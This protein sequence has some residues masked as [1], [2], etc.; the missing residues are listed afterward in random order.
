MRLPL[1]CLM[2]HLK[3]SL[4]RRL[5]IELLLVTFFGCSVVASAATNSIPLTGLPQNTRL[6]IWGDSITEVTVYPRYI[7]MYLLACAG[8]KDIK[9]CTFGHSGETLAG[10][11]SR[12]IDLESF[13]PT[14]VMFNEGMNDTKYSPYTPEKGAAYDQT[15]K[16]VL[17]MLTGKGITQKI[18]AGPP[19]VDDTY[20]ADAAGTSAFFGGTNTGGLTAAQ[21]QNVNLRNFS[22]FGRT[23]AVNTGSAF[24]DIFDRMQESYKAA[25]AVYGPKYGYEIHS[26][27]NGC[28]LMD[29]E[30]LKTL[31]CDGS[32]GAINVDMNGGATASAGHTVV[33]CSNGAVVLDSSKYPFCYNYDPNNTQGFKSLDSMLPYVPFSRDLNR[34]TL[35]VTNLKAPSANVTWGGQTKSFTSAQLTAGVNLAEQFSQTPF[36]ATFAQVMARIVNK[37]NYED[38]MIKGTSNYFGND[39]GGNVDNNMIAVETSLDAA[40]KALIVPVRHTIAIVPTGAPGPVVPVITGAMMAYPMVGQPFAYQISALNTPTSFS[41]TGLPAGLTMNTAGQITGTPTATGVSVASI[42]AA[43]ASGTSETTLTLTVQ[44]PVPN[45]PAITSS[46]AASGM[47]GAPFSYQTTATNNPA[48]YFVTVPSDKG[49]EPPASS[50]PTGITYNT[51]SGLVSGTFTTAG[52]YKLQVA[53]MN[54]AGVA[55]QFVTVTVSAGSGNSSPSTPAGST[56]AAAGNG[57]NK[58]L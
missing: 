32:I 19:F 49:T 40:V 37:Q 54:G 11:L 5:Y 28:I 36:D 17:A 23:E 2:T 27:P 18:V 21:G 43:N 33:S 6:A 10:L 41:A 14:I 34:L 26:M 58:R 52:T 48:N 4:L 35:T 22:A 30:M 29:Y 15:M 7:E 31:G 25:E 24:A 42:S 46:T 12:G 16:Q 44:A 8:R 56:A 13:N 55:A 9:V 38:F 51:N 3:S 1:N 57:Q 39:N 47:V 45:V 50:L 53:A 20:D